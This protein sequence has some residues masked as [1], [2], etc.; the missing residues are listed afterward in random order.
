MTSAA[1]TSGSAC[2]LAAMLPASCALAG[3]QPATALQS[4]YVHS[5]LE[6]GEQIVEVSQQGRDVRVRTITMVQ[7]HQQ[8]PGVIVRAYRPGSD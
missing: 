1:R 5:Q 4:F 7:A 3:A 2:L 6:R 8:C